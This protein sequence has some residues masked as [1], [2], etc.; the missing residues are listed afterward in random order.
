MF[1]NLLA[2]FKSNFAYRIAMDAKSKQ[3]DYDAIPSP[4][5]LG[6][7]VLADFDGFSQWWPSVI[8]PDF[9]TKEPRYTR[10]K[11]L[12][13]MGKARGPF[14]FYH[15]QWIGLDHKVAWIPKYRLS[16]C[17]DEMLQTSSES[18]TDKKTRKAYLKF[19]GKTNEE[20]VEICRV[21]FETFD[22]FKD[23][24]SSSKLV[25]V[26]DAEICDLKT[27]DLDLKFQLQR[28]KDNFEQFVNSQNQNRPLTEQES[29]SNNEDQA[30]S[31]AE[32]NN[33]AKIQEENDQLKNELKIL[34]ES[35]NEIKKSFQ[36]LKN[37][38]MSFKQNKPRNEQET[39][40][41]NENTENENQ[42]STNTENTEESDSE[43]LFGFEQPLKKIKLEDQS[44]E[45]RKLKQVNKNL[46]EGNSQLQKEVAKLTK[47]NEDYE[48]VQ[49]QNETVLKN[50]KEENLKLHKEILDL[51][52][53]HHGSKSGPF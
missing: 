27:Y 19:L 3:I 36:D 21:R 20:R 47:A 16:A 52:Y 7:L 42:I 37:I 15:V 46:K 5:K 24:P 29:G 32:Q 30:P 35:Q 31:N 48:R 2:N 1:S 33:A 18:L 13:M 8:C 34:K 39:N 23:Q 6:E 26:V 49:N 22:A 41:D 44:E 53:V 45:I 14:R 12:M 9:S 50:L 38:V 28:L 4:F 51:K 10:V 11:K 40:Y 43:N 25:E 17:N